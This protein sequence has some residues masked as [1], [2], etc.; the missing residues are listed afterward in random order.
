MTYL[1]KADPGALGAA[2]RAYRC[3][4]PYD[5]DPQNYAQATAFVPTSCEDEVATLLAALHRE[6]DAQPGDPE[7]RF[8]AEGNARAVVGAE[9][10]YRAMVWGGPESWNVR[11]RHM[12]ETLENLMA[13][14]GSQAKAIVWEHNTHIGDA[15]A[16]DIVGDGMVNVGHLVREQHAADG[17]VLVGFGSYEGEVIAGERWGAPMERM[18]VPPARA[19]SWEEVFH[20]AGRRSALLLSENLRDHA[21][22][23]AHRGH[24]AIGVIYRPAYDRGN[25][26]P[27]ILP[28]RYDAFIYLGV[29]TALHPLHLE[30]HMHGVPETY[31]WGV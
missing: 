22:A 29:T 20:R 16:T 23:F 25:Y 24:R 15:R 11:D 7:A 19:G 8:N 17:V 1:E 3:F 18:R 13:Y 4:E 30:P 10:Y 5:E 14:H 28:E 27:T 26:V 12:V 6:A 21:A 31:P 2:R 9:R